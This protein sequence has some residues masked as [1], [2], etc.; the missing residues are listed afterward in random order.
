MIQEREASI[1]W[2]FWTG[3][4]SSR[5]DSPAERQAAER[6]WAQRQAAEAQ[7]SALMTRPEGES[8]RASLREEGSLRPSRG[9]KTPLISLIDMGTLYMYYWVYFGHLF[10]VNMKSVTLCVNLLHD[11]PPRMVPR[12]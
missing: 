8:R 11:A 10:S 6:Q 12:I 5:A 3:P 7:H 2:R 1:V 9:T 4:T